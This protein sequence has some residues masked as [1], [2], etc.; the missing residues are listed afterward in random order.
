MRILRAIAPVALLALGLA[1]PAAA[2]EM[3]VQAVDYEFM[4]RTLK[5][6]PGDDVT[7]TFS[8]EAEH[9]AT[10]VRGQA[11]RFSSGLKTAGGTYSHTFTRPGRYQYIC[12]PHRYTMRGTIQVGDDAIATSF[13]KVSTTVRGRRATSRLQL[14]EAAG[15]SGVVRGPKTLRVTVRRTEAGPV[16]V[17]WGKRLKAGRYAGTITAVDDFDKKTVKAVRFKIA[18]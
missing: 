8:G 16:A 10:S 6:A 15:V 7:W 5:V 14:A 17:A 12:L 11:E 4:P 18:D 1:A 3:S 13:G 9:T 2:G